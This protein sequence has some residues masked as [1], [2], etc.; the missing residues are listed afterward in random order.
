MSDF[1]L[2]AAD[3][4][5]EFYER[6]HGLLDK[7]EMYDGYWM[8]NAWV[9]KDTIYFSEHFSVNYSPK[10]YQTFLKPA[11]DRLLR[12]YQYAMSY[13]Y[14]SAGKHIIAEYFNRGRP[15]W[16]QSCDNDPPS[17]IIERFQGQV[18]VTIHTTASQFQDTY[19]RYGGLGVHYRVRCVS[20]KE[21]KELCSSLA[22]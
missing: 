13:V 15:V 18:L 1:A 14:C 7:Q 2:Y 22:Q 6:I 20:L 17:N 5:V 21:A 12:N 19:S 8:T 11:N 4:A 10:M 3:I 9:P 16:I